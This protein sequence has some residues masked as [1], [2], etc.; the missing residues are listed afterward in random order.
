MLTA[1]FEAISL[2]QRLLNNSPLFSLFALPALPKALPV[3]PSF[4]DG[5]SLQLSAHLKSVI[6]A[7]LSFPRRRE[8][9]THHPSPWSSR[10]ALCTLLSAQKS[11]TF[12]LFRSIFLSKDSLPLT[13]R[14][15]MRNAGHDF[16]S[17]TPDSFL[18]LFSTSIYRSARPSCISRPFIQ[19]LTLETIE[20]SEYRIVGTINQAVGETEISKCDESP[21]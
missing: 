15:Q 3:R 19:P 1:S 16:K 21:H 18:L 9:R 2:S 8:S 10:F 5:G 6:P 12:P 14:V 11:S 13:I 7:P 17:Y 20:K 4:S